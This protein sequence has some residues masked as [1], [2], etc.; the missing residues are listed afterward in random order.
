MSLSY[1]S[2]ELKQLDGK[3]LIKLRSFFVY[4]DSLY[5]ST[6]SLYSSAE[7]NT[8]ALRSVSFWMKSLNPRLA[9]SAKDRFTSALWDANHKKLCGSWMRKEISSSAKRR[10]SLI[11]TLSVKFLSTS[12]TLALKD[13]NIFSLL[14]LPNSASCFDKLWKLS[15]ENKFDSLSTTS[16]TSRSELKSL[17]RSTHINSNLLI[18]HSSTEQR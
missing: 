8:A 10:S 4:T 14:N 7:I 6:R 18:I 16:P 3:S 12:Q 9:A 1:F 17:R 5:G 2:T 11:T 15:S 13:W